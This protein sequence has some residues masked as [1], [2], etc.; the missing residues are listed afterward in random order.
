MNL[1]IASILFYKLRIY[2]NVNITR[3]HTGGHSHFLFLLYYLNEIL[4]QFKLNV[5]CVLQLVK[6]ELFLYLFIETELTIE[7]VNNNNWKND[8]DVYELVYFF[9]ET[10]VEFV[11][12]FE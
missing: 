4:H 3:D 6:L 2:V 11:F 9:I 5:E 12:C 10:I 7:V 8:N 1:S